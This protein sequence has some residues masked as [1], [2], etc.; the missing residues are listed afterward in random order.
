MH[1]KRRQNGIYF[2]GSEAILYSVKLQLLY[3]LVLFEL[4]DIEQ[5]DYYDSIERCVKRWN[6]WNDC[7]ARFLNKL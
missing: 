6:E 7:L 3:R 5:M 2:N 1:I 4:L